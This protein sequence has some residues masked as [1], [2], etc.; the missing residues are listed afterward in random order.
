MDLLKQKI[1][2]E[3]SASGKEILKVDAFLNHQLDVR[4]FEAMGEEF[5]RRFAGQGVNKLLTIETSGIAIAAVVAKYFDYCPVVFGKKNVSL[6]LDKEIYTSEVYSF[7]KQ[8]TYQV[9]VSKKYL[10][11]GDRVLI[12]DDFLANGKAVEALKDIVEQAGATLV[13]VGIAI[14]KG[15]QKGGKELRN[16]GVKLESLAI[17]QEMKEDGTI[18]FD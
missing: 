13:G 18:V 9:M 15:F 2:E 1:V 8:T 12:I 6:N 10:N 7:T 5:A 17:V 11:A 4:L 3:G 14:E 16:A